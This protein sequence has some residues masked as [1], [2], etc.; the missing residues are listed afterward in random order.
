MKEIL[1]FQKLHDELD[2]KWAAIKSANDKAK[3]YTAVIEYLK[4]LR[5]QYETGIIGY[6]TFPY[7]VTSL[8]SID[9]E[10][11]YPELEP[12]MSHAADI[13]IP[14]LKGETNPRNRIEVTEK[15]SEMIKELLS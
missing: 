15:L 8:F 13:E 14:N 5:T 4:F 6:I 3:K 2:M 11:D 10:E 12:L 7:Y 9:V 1:D